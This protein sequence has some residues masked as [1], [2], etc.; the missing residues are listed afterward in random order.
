MCVLP[1]APVEGCR[2]LHHGQLH[3][4]EHRAKT[5]AVERTTW[6]DSW[7]RWR[8]PREQGEEPGRRETT[9]VCSGEGKKGY[10]TSIAL[11]PPERRFQQNDGR[12]QAG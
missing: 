7:P 9:V 5:K 4:L 12:W 1:L 8:F 6:P 10:Y 3:G 2:A 11:D